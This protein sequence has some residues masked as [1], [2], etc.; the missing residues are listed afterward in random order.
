M[1][2][3]RFH[4]HKGGV[5]TTTVASSVACLLAH[6]GSKTLLIDAGTNPDTY[7]WLGAPNPH[8]MENPFEV[9]ENL[10]V[11]RATSTDDVL[12]LDKSD[13]ECVVLDAGQSEVA[14]TPSDDHQE[15]VVLRNDYLSLRNSVH[16]TEKCDLA[17]IVVEEGRPLTVRDCTQVLGIEVVPMPID[18]AFARSIDAG[19]SYHRVPNLV[20]EVL[21]SLIF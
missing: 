18:T 6:N 4:S 13:Y 11:V 17:V 14:L 8:I 5:G 7:G 9:H 19:L 12:F 20:G 2:T 15:V 10:W 3:Y 21:K 1:K 16:K